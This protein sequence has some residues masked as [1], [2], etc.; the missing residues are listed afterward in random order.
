[1]PKEYKGKESDSCGQ[2]ESP[3]LICVALFDNK[4]NW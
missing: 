4:I 1:M 2:G 3:D